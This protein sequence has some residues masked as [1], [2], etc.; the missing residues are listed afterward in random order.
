MP[1]APSTT[2]AGRIRETTS[3]FS[4]TGYSF[5]PRPL[6]SRASTTR[7]TASTAAATASGD[8]PRRARMIAAYAPFA[9][10]CAR[11]TGNGMNAS[12]GCGGPAGSFRTN[13]NSGGNTPMTV[14]GRPCS[15]TS[16][17]DDAGVGS[18]PVPQVVRQHNHLLARPA[19]LVGRKAA[20]ERG[21]DAEQIE[22]VR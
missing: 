21:R 3:A 9:F 4:P 13:A 1:A 22:Q 17:A 7:P 16:D 19:D 18:E 10:V 5:S 20:A 12:T 15:R 14:N 11:S 6:K 2:S 8:V